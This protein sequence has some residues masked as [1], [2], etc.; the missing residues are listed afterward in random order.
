MAALG[1][2]LV[3]P[4]VMQLSDLYGRRLTYVIPVYVGLVANLLCAFAPSYTIFLVFR[5]IAGVAATVSRRPVRIRAF[6][7]YATN[8]MTLS[9]E[10]VSTE[11][12]SLIP[13]AFNSFWIIGYLMAGVLKL[14]INEWRYLYIAATLPGLLCLPY[15]WLIPESLHWLVNVKKYDEVKKYIK[16]C[17][18]YNGEKIDLH[19]C[20]ALETTEVPISILLV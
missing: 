2:M 1:G 12:R 6:Q 16:K 8:A 20:Q 3:A 5:F 18:R 17:E 4:L 14:Y 19:A 7:S 15:Y 11:F 9:L 10:S 13:I